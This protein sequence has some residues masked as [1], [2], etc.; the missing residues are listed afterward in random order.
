[1][2]YVVVTFMLVVMAS[3]PA[4]ADC[5]ATVNRAIDRFMDAQM[6]EALKNEKMTSEMQKMADDM[7][8]EMKPKLKAAMT[9]S[10]IDDKWSSEAVK[11]VDDAA[12]T[13]AMDRCESTLSALQ[14]AN[15]ERAMNAALDTASD[16]ATAAAC[17]NAAKA[18]A[19]LVLG[20]RAP[21]ASASAKKQVER[22]HV[23]GTSLVTDLAG[24]CF[25][26][27]WS[28]D[29]IACMKSASSL[30][31]LATCHQELAGDVDEHIQAVEIG[32]IGSATDCVKTTGRAVDRMTD[33]AE[34][35]RA[36][37][38][39]ALAESCSADWWPASSLS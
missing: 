5:A 29:A 14:K 25:G 13:D 7:V 36:H 21:P 2:N 22:R 9:R 26:D 32:A 35:K 37:M 34:A 16:D 38:A 30:T 15:L 1:M 8:N 4:H 39:W 20:L 11:C 24:L 27:R 10:C 28:E 17:G 33:V 31:D 12:D 3:A 23:A 18:V 19:D 6:K